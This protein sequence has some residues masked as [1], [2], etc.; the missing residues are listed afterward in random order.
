MSTT[1]WTN[2][3]YLLFNGIGLFL[4]LFKQHALILTDIKMNSYFIYWIGVKTITT[5]TSHL[6]VFQLQSNLNVTNWTEF[7]TIN[8]QQLIWVSKYTKNV[9]FD[10]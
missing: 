4:P 6:N 8:T 7:N 5:D 1:G 9:A 3:T 2:K 10:E